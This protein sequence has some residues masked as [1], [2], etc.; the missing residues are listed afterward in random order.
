MDWS[1]IPDLGAVSLLAGAF[2]SIAKQGRT[3]ASRIW[4]ICWLMI[5]LHFAASIF[6]PLPGA[7]GNIADFVSLSALADAGILF[8]YS[9][10]PY[11]DQISNRWMLMT[12]LSSITLYLGLLTVTPL[13]SWTL[14]PAAVLIG[15]APLV[16]AV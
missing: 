4:L 7:I 9:T 3:R 11:H 10:I 2:A 6:A 5:C 1:Q 14:V 13:W 16:I 12:L 15:G 8:M